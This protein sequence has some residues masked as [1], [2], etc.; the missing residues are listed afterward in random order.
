MTKKQIKTKNTEQENIE[1]QEKDK[2]F[3]IASFVCGILFWVPLFNFVLGIMAIIFGVLAIKRIKKEPEKY[4]GQG[5]AI[6]GI[7]LG[8]IAL[9]FG[10]VYA[11]I[12]IFLPELLI[13]N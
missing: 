5:F 6:A 1:K 13:T 9:M 4:G 3:S 12:R 10:I 7:I 11:I 8:S 2:A